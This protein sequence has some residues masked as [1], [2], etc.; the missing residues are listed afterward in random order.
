MVFRSLHRDTPIW[1]DVCCCSPEPRWQAVADELEQQRQANQERQR[2]IAAPTDAA[3]L[4]ADSASA[5]P[6]AGESRVSQPP[7]AEAVF[8]GGCFWCV[9]AVFEELDGVHEVISGYAGGDAKTANY[10]AVCNGDTGHAEA[11]LIR[12]DPARISFERLLEVHFA[13]H[14]PTTLNRQGNDVGTQYRSA[15]FYADEAQRAAAQAFIASLNAAKVF[16]RPIVTTLEPLV[17]FF[18]AETYHQ[19]Y[20]C[21]NPQ[22]PY[23]QFAALPKVAKV[24]KQFAAQLKPKSPLER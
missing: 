12:Y 18:P 5:Q 2:S 7:L 22:Q 20:V 24:R 15:I 11:V 16:T 1:E 21:H 10:E 8:A 3:R 14:D 9:E 4:P 13:T 23:V 17:K 6:L 19:N